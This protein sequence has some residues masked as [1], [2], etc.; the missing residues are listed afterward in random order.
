[1]PEKNEVYSKNNSV[2]LVENYLFIEQIFV[3]VKKTAVR[4]HRFLSDVNL[5]MKNI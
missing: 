4:R 1:M 5:T 3:I 2:E